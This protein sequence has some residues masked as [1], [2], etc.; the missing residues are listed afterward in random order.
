MRNCAVLRKALLDDLQ[1]Q[2]HMLTSDMDLAAANALW[3]SKSFWKKFQDDIDEAADARCFELFKKSNERCAAFAF[4]PQSIQDDEVIGE[5]KSLWWDIIGNGPESNLHMAEIL[6][7]G[8]VGPGASVGARSDNFYTKLFDSTLTGTSDQLYRY[9]RYAIL[10]YPTH[11]SAEVERDKRY[12]YKIVGGNRLSFVPK[13]AEISRSICTEPTLN[14]Y[15]QKG[16]GTSLEKMLRNKFKIDLSY[17]P[18]LNRKLAQLGSIDGSFGTIDLSSASDSISLKMLEQALPDELVRLLKFAR[19]P[20]VVY[21][22]GT[23]NEL[24]MVSSMGNGFTFPLQTLLFSTIVVSCYRV[25]GIKPEYGRRG[26]A[27]WAVFGDDII[28]RKDAYDFV[29]RTL[30]LFGFSVNDD[31][32]FNCGSFRES[33]G[34]DYFRGHN[35]RG[36][37]CKSLKT[38]ADVY[39]VT[40]RLIRW[41][42]RTG[43]LLPKTMVVL[44]GMAKFLPIPF[45]DGDA[46]GIKTPFPPADLRRD[47]YTGSIIYHALVKKPST[48]KLPCSKDENL[49]FRHY[50]RRRKVSFN[51]D[52]LLVSFIGGFVR[53]GRIGVRVQTDSFKVRRCLTSRWMSWG[54]SVDFR[55]KIAQLTQSK[56]LTKNRA[57]VREGIDVEA[58]LLKG[59]A[60]DWVII[61]DLYLSL[62]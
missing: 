2:E 41:S 13:T 34:G 39:S 40:N 38:S 46:E 23:L 32:S 28:V 18:I 16:I 29:V 3:L 45:H 50:G 52:G 6:D 53:N 55:K 61:C 27:N 56:Y 14:M 44:L 59:L 21:P 33:C 31:K 49:T 54:L 25:L 15:F 9:Y 7:H 35:I 17:Q 57:S 30:N 48:I 8:G 4:T 62:K 26:P 10:N 1:V 37:Y 5:V 51:P 43:I 42:A 47:P 22:N 36:V 11:L 24:Y 19:S 20:S 60:D 12:G 58:D